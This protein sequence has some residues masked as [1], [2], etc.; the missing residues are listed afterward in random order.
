P[1][2]GICSGDITVIE[3]IPEKI[4]P[5]LLPFIIQNDALFDFAVGKSA[6]S[7][8]PRVKWEHL[9]NYSFELPDMEEQRRLAKVLWAMDATKKAYQKLIQKTDELVKSQFIAL[10]GDPI[11]NPKSWPTLTIGE[12]TEDIL[13]GQCLNG[14]SGVL[15]PGMKA[16]LKVSAVT[17]GYFK[18]DEYKVLNDTSQ[19]TKGIYPQKGDL[20]FSRANTKEYVGATAL[21]DQDYP[22]LMLPDKLW[23]LYFK[24]IISPIFAKHFLSHPETRAVLSE[25][26]TGTSGSMFNISMEK[27]KNLTFLVMKMENLL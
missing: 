23:K 20:I 9:K 21:I 24:P 25:M 5:E 4:L 10:F 18:A 22:D 1:F 3:A 12:A 2:D 13:S 19:I 6:G 27:L 7:L 11:K 15:L 16:V 17:Y 8:S 14:S 26:A